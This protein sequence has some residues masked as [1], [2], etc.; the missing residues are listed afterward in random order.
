MITDLGDRKTQNS[1]GL[2]SLSYSYEYNIHKHKSIQN[3]R[4]IMT[5]IRG[6]RITD[7]GDK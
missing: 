6:T 3:Y 2:L 4:Y 5:M 1:S 7:D